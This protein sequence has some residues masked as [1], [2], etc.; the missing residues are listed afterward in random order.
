MLIAVPGAS[1]LGGVLGVNAGR[2]DALLGALRDRFGPFRHRHVL[3]LAPRHTAAAAREQA[4]IVVA[5]DPAVRICVLPLRH[6]GL[7]LALIGRA[8]LA[9][10]LRPDGWTDPGQA[11]QLVLSFAARSRSLVWHPRLG[12]VA[13]PGVTL[14]ERAAS[15]LP[16]RS[17]FYELGTR[18][19][20]P[21]RLGLGIVSP[22]GWYATG[23]PSVLLEAGLGGVVPEPVLQF[24]AGDRPY[25]GRNSVEISQLVPPY[26]API[27]GP[28]CPSCTATLIG[29]QCAFCG[30]GPVGDLDPQTG[31]PIMVAPIERGVLL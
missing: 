3:V 26:A 17:Y 9:A 25:A 8:V 7:T 29:A 18:G 11:V 4:H 22:D 30:C 20:I 1:D 6:H 14:A 12:S 15:L 28:A 2:P 16:A 31:V 24:P 27:Q 13:E 23:T 10:E 21:A 5:S 19:L